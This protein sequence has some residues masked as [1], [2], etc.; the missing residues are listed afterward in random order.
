[1]EAEV[2]LGGTQGTIGSL[3]IGEEEGTDVRSNGPILI[4]EVLQDMEDE[5]AADVSQGGHIVKR[6]ARSRPVSGE[7]IDNASGVMRVS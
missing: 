2:F 1:V 6:R 4:N 5:E 3:W 7:L